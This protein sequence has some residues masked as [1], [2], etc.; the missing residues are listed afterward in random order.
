MSEHPLFVHLT[1]MTKHTG[2]SG[3]HTIFSLDKKHKR[4]LINYIEWILH[5]LQC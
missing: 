1:C 5:G 2:H 3:V 4:L